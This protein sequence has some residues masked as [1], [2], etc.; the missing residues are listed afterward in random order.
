MI[1]IKQSIAIKKV[2]TKD[3]CRTIE[4]NIKDITGWN[5]SSCEL[6]KVCPGKGIEI[7]MIRNIKL[8]KYVFITVGASNKD[9]IVINK[10]LSEHRYHF[11][12]IM[13]VSAEQLENKTIAALIKDYNNG[14]ANNA[15]AVLVGVA[16]MAKKSTSILVDKASFG[17]RTSSNQE[18]PTMIVTKEWENASA[19]DTVISDDKYGI[20]LE[21]FARPGKLKLIQVIACTESES[22][23]M[24]S[25]NDEDLAVM[26]GISMYINGYDEYNSHRETFNFANILPT[27]KISDKIVKKLKLKTDKNGLALI[28]DYTDFEAL[29][30]EI[31]K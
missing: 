3:M 13:K 20:E 18:V 14:K 29:L 8:K 30:E 25:M 7:L 28:T 10:D 26:S 27:D 6:G 19:K 15:I 5:K 11:E 2:D 22:K 4:S 17:V 31:Y 21:S 16:I 24:I 9:A 23:F 12:Y 1:G